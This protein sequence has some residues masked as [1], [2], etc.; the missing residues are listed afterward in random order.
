MTPAPAAPA[1]RATTR[2]TKKKKAKSKRVP[3][4]TTRDL[5]AQSAWEK[6]QRLPKRKRKKLTRPRKCRVVAPKPGAKPSPTGP[7]AAPPAVAPVADAFPTPPVAAPVD[8]LRTY[9]GP[10]GVAQAQRLLFRAG[11]GPRPGQADAVAALG[12]RGAVDALLRP[13]PARLEGPAPTGAFLVGGQFAPADRYGHLHL[14]TF[15]RQIRSTDQLGERLTLVLHD[16]F[17]VSDSAVDRR[18]MPAHFELL[19][20]GWRGSFRQLL[21]DVTQDPAMLQFLDGTANRRGAPNE[22]YARELMELYGLGADRGAYTEDDVREMARALTGFRNDFTDELG[23]YNFRYD[24]ARHDAGV[25]TVFAGTAYERAGRLGWQDA[26]HA[27]VDHPLHPS[28]VA[29]KLWSAFIPTEPT[30]ET[31]RQLEALYRSSGERLEPLVEAIL[32]HPDLHAGP[33]M[34]KPPVVFAAGLL[35]ASGQGVST[36]TWISRL[37]AAGQMLGDPPNVAGWN[38]RAWLNT[39]THSARWGIVSEALRGRVVSSAAYAGRT[40]TPPDAVESALA[41]WG[42]PLLTDDHALALRRVSQETWTRGTSGDTYGSLE[43]FLAQRQNVL[44]QLVCAAPDLQVS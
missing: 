7:V 24:P 42:N 4:C 30:A 19:R 9:T 22:N 37:A 40:E 20:R 25:K 10:F 2:K 26:V 1:R 43:S 17:A 31:Q 3:V 32:L 18:L 13:G 21:L 33:T 27:V 8:G 16:W 34:V 36:E 39:S 29:R 44:R 12:L 6:N 14:A 23:P 41:A 5:K 11:F 38:D 28:F 35:R 15:D